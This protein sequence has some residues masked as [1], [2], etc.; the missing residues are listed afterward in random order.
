M[1]DSVLDQHEIDALLS[2]MGTGEVELETQEAVVTQR[3]APYD[4]K[5]PERVARDQLRSIGTLHEVF[6]R[7]LQA[8]LSGSLRTIID[9][10]IS[11]VDQ[12]TYSEFINSLPNPTNFN[13]ISC[14]PLEGN[15]ILEIN[16]SIAFPI[17]ERLL[18]SGRV[19][20]ELPERPLT[21]IERRLLQ[22][23]TDKMLDLLKEA[24]ATFIDI[25]FHITAQESNPQ[26]MPIMSSNEPVIGVGIE[27]TFGGNRGLINICI[28]VVSIESILGKLSSYTWFTH[29]G[30]GSSTSREGVIARSVASA[31]VQLVT[32]LASATITLGKLLSLA[33]GDIITTSH[34]IDAPVIAYI[35][36]KP[37]FWVKPG[38]FKGHK[39]VKIIRSV[40][41]A[42]DLLTI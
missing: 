31:Q 21:D 15:F 18:G 42:K 17:F 2:A 37:K 11:H 28:P 14:E 16:P 12:L 13:V 39:A 29:K 41:L 20:T 27:I 26:L 1:A 36:G 30:K 3:I 23:I 7:N 10:N 19:G 33:P 4:F 8:N 38:S 25:N 40:D 22:S 9:V 6:A 5:R 32:Y 24:W 34:P 35:E